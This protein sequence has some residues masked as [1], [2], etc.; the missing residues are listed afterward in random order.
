MKVALISSSYHPYYRGGGE[1]SVKKLAEGLATQG[2]IVTVITAFHNDEQETVEGVAVYRIKHPNIYWSYTSDQQ[3]AYLRLIWHLLEGYNIRVKKPLQHLINQIKPDI[4]HI[5]N[6]EDFSPYA[7]KVAYNLGIPVVV[8]LNSY[9]WLCPRA[10]MFRNG[11]NCSRQCLDC[12]LITYSKKIASQ[13]VNAVVG[14]SRFMVN[15]HTQYSYFPKASQHVIYTSMESSFT[16]LAFITNNYKTFGFIGRIHPSKG[17][18]EIIKAFINANREKRHRLLIAG[19]GS[20]DYIKRCQELAQYSSEIVFLGK[21]DIDDFYPKVDI[22]VI[23]SQWH[24]PFPRV[25]VEAY[26]Y[27][28][29]VIATDTGGIPEMVSKETGYIVSH[30]QK[31]QLE[32]TLMHF[33]EMVDKKLLSMQE[34]VKAF[35]TQNMHNEFQSYSKLYESLSLQKGKQLK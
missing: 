25:L 31:K 6:V 5:R 22:V 10:T 30:K 29:P 21:V 23:N 11:Q 28:R 13:Y 8:T 19:T 17:V 16:K 24:E 32:R 1:Y 4:V 9:T 35:F 15:R 33:M 18:L 7:C 34:N 3:P 14:V 12:K 20:D 27:G 2:H 26:A